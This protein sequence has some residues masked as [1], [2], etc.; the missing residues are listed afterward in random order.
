MPLPDIQWTKNE[1]PIGNNRN[2]HIKTQS[3][4]NDNE[5]CL[6]T[7]LTIHVNF[8]FFLFDKE[9]KAFNLKDLTH[10]RYGRYGCRAENYLGYQSHHIDYYPKIGKNSIK[11]FFK[12]NSIGF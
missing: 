5:D 2:F 7:I 12:E 9:K 4:I 1:I 6:K 10:D 8:N 3:N 11:I